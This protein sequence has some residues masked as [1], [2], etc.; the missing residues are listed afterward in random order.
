MICA[1]RIELHAGL[2][3][4]AEP[5]NGHSR[6]QRVWNGR[7]HTVGVSVEKNRH[8]PSELTWRY[9]L[10]GGLFYLREQ[11]ETIRVEKSFQAGRVKLQQSQRMD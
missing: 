5:R 1:R 2:R 9:N 6:I 7:E 4:S 10:M 8:E 11:G 3:H